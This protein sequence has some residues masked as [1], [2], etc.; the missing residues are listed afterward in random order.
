MIRTSAMRSAVKSVAKR[1]TVVSTLP[2][3]TEDS[4]AFTGNSPCHDHGRPRTD[5]ATKS[6]DPATKTAGSES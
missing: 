1:I 2:A 3:L 4:A 6:H 5:A